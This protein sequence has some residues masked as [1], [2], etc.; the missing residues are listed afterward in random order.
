MTRFSDSLQ[1]F[2][3]RLTEQAGVPV[4]VVRGNAIIAT[5]TAIPAKTRVEYMTDSG[6]RAS[7][8]VYDFVVPA[9][10]GWI[11]ERGDR[12]LWV[13]GSYIVRPVGAEWWRYDDA[14]RTFLRVHTQQ[15]VKKE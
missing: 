9:S 1:K 3:A 11:P 15:E 4:L 13:G 8:D 6:V 7:N 12:I 5:V 14:E 10:E 2:K